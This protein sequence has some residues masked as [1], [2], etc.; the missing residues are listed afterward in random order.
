MLAKRSIE[1]QFQKGMLE[2]INAEIV[3]GTITDQREA[4]EYLRYTYYYIRLLQ[5]PLNYGMDA[6]IHNL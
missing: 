5:N 1:S 3:L 2:S 4:M 6:K